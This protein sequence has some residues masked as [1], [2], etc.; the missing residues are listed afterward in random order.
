MYNLILNSKGNLTAK[1][2]KAFVTF[3]KL[4]EN[5]HRLMD[6]TAKFAKAS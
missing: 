3:T 1:F 2:D 5:S 6:L 4:K